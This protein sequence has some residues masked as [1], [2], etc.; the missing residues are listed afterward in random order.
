M[1]ASIPPRSAASEN[2]RAVRRSLRRR[3]GRRFRRFGGDDR[4]S[5]ALIFA[6]LI[7]ALCLFVGAAVD[8][9]SALRAKAAMQGASDA[10]V[11]AAAIHLKT[12]PSDIAT[13]ETKAR[14]VYL[15]NRES[16]GF[17]I[18]G[19]DIRFTL[20]RESDGALMAEAF[21][22]GAV[23]THFTKVVHMNSL[24]V[25]SYSAARI[26]RMNVEMALVLDVTL[27]MQGS[28][29]ST[30]KTAATELVKE[31]V[32]DDQSVWQSRIALIPFSY[33]VNTSDLP[34]PIS[35]IAPSPSHSSDWKL[36]PGC[37]SERT[38]ANRFSDTLASVGRVYSGNTTCAVPRARP[39]SNNINTLNANIS[40]LVARGSTATHIGA[41]WG[42]YALSPNWAGRFGHTVKPY[43]D[44]DTAKYLVI[45]SDGENTIQYC[46]HGRP[47]R[48]SSIGVLNGGTDDRK[49]ATCTGTSADTQLREICTDAKR[50]GIEVITVGFQVSNHA[51]TLLTQC[52]SPSSYYN[53]N[54]NAALIQAFR[55]IA[56]RVNKLHLSH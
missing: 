10:A 9:G 4:G 31:V 2:S 50:Q 28:K 13:A 30:L 25:S 36:Q 47:D 5:V 52:A 42:Y 39:L 22:E 33:S 12:A 53:A 21:A 27:S 8:F 44:R 56:S 35:T 34:G 6:L 54:S 26:E 46:G 19:E 17:T 20:T 1:S 37:V 3:L 29:L 40:A 55:D 32:W 11:L 51:R 49:K 15:A 7:L 23:A 24:P 43:S 14:A 48:N 16:G 41:A 18:D 45:M 38:D